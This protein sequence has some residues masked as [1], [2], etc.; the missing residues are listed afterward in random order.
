MKLR[1]ITLLFILGTL[2][3]ARPS[4]DVIV[5][6]NGDH[7]TCEIKRLDEGV[8]YI[9]LSYVDGTVSVQW[10]KVDHIESHQLFLVQT[11]DGSQYMGELRTQAKAGDEPVKIEVVE[12]GN[13]RQVLYQR[14]V[15]QLS[16]AGSTFWRK[17]SGDFDG[18][19]SYSR[20][21][22]TRQLNLSGDILFLS[23]LWSA[24]ARYTSSFSASNHDSLANR[25]QLTLG[26]RRLI[27]RRQ[28]FYSGIADFLQ[29][30][31]Q[32]IANQSTLG[33][34]L[35]R[36]LKNTDRVRISL[37]GGLAFQNTRY[38]S[39]AN[40][41]QQSLSGLVAGNVQLFVF[42]KT[43]LS[44]Q[45][46]VLPLL[47]QPGRVRYGT[48]LSYSIQIINNLWWRFTFYGNWDNHP[49]NNLPGSDYGTTSSLSYSFNYFR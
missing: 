49:P 44:L 36:F 28:W 13:T 29:S 40:P 21:N 26:A 46:T 19:M 31:Q 2:L 22:N 18:G 12:S 14:Q 24:E 47:N 45:G 1:V 5:M 38:E 16:E 9:G 6:K 48:N 30:T 33:G 4:T 10:S 17:F 34:G 43:T 35:G 41:T 15:V 11:Q 8:L 20:G 3:F 37:T 32:G 39:P 27:A 42:K 25:N 23:S 7:L